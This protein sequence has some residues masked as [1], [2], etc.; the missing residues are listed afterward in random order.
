V[1]QQ[2]MFSNARKTWPLITS[3]TGENSLD[4]GEDGQSQCVAMI[5][6]RGLASRGIKVNN[7]PIDLRAMVWWTFQDFPSS[8]PDE[9]RYWK[10]GIVDENVTPKPSYYAYQTLT[11]Q[12]SG[13]DY[14]QALS[15]S[16]GLKRIEAYKFINGSRTKIV[17]WSDDIPSG[18][19]QNIPCAWTRNPRT[20]TFGP[21]V[22]RLSVTDMYGLTNIVDDGGPDDLDPRR[23]YIGISVQAPLYV[24]VN[25]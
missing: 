7:K 23:G 1:I 12:L 22:T 14:Q 5:F 18:Q 10:F 24:Q 4:I 3:E 8:N 21:R 19:P 25:P 17:L 15:N 2:R 16:R 11:Q 9:S 6:V 20:A 13:L